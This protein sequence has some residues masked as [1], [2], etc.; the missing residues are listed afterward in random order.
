[1]YKSN[2]DQ[3]NVNISLYVDYFDWNEYN[4]TYNDWNQSKSDFNPIGTISGPSQTSY[5]LQIP[6]I[7]L[8]RSFQSS[9][10]ITFRIHDNTNGHPF[11][12]YSKETNY[13]SILLIGNIFFFFDRF[14]NY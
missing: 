7:Y 14:K 9:K 1:M 4:F 2:Q 13:G 11:V 10:K 3:S 8:E 5:S 12:F 6:L